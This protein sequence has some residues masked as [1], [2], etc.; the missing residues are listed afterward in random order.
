LI[1]ALAGNDFGT[2]STTDA[3]ISRVFDITC[4]RY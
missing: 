3:R 2:G 4:S 1:L